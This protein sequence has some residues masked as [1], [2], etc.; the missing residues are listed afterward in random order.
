MNVIVRRGDIINCDSDIMLL[1]VETDSHQHAYVLQKGK[2]DV[3][4][5][6]KRALRIVNDIQ[7]EVRKEFIVGCTA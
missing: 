6:L 3:P 1:G 7:D 4:E 5:G 2:E